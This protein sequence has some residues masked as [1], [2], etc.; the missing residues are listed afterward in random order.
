MR[1][2]PVRLVL[3][4]ALAATGCRHVR[5]NQRERLASPAM[6]FQM[7]PVADGQRDSILEITEGNTFPSAG[8]GTAGAGCGCN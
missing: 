4:I 6:Q 3:V 1:L 2:P 5:P 7:E 8:P